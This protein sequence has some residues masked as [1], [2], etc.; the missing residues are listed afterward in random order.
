MNDNEQDRRPAYDIRPLR[1]RLFG[2]HCGVA[3]ML[4]LV[5]VFGYALSGG[6]RYTISGFSPVVWLVGLV[7]L[8]A[9]G[10]LVMWFGLWR[11]PD[12]RKYLGDVWFVRFCPR[13]G[14]RLRP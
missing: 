8:Y 6:G 5:I 1:L 2:I 4:L 14:V 12:C 13:C 7:S 11:C 9:I 3:F 10:A